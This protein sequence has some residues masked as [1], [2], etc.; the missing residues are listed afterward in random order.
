MLIEGASFQLQP[1][2]IQLLY[3]ASSSELR[4]QFFSAGFWKMV[5]HTFMIVSSL[6]IIIAFSS[7][8]L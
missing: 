2:R 5:E 6:F 1:L 3:N 7:L 8:K 4:A